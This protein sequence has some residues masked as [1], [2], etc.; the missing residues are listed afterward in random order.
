MSQKYLSLNSDKS[1]QEI[2]DYLNDYK[3]DLAKKCNEFV[4]RLI[5]YGIE[6]AKDNV[7]E[8]GEYIVFRKELDSTDD[9]VEGMLIATNGRKL[10]REWYTDKA[11]TN[12]RSY[13]VSPLLLAEFGSGWLARVYVNVQ[14][15]GQGT[16]PNA[17]GH[18]FD[19]SGWWWYDESGEK[20]HSVGEAPTY[21]MHTAMLAMMFEIDKIGKE[22]FGN[23]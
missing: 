20:H 2:I 15:V 1:Y 16:M 7:G 4:S 13:E 11:T 14:G 9:G 18:A 22:V 17:Y 5:D 8:Y 6:I 10:V 19:E 3:V 21:P 12:K 23:G